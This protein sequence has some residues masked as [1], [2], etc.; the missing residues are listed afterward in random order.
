MFDFSTLAEDGEERARHFI[1]GERDQF[2]DR[3]VLQQVFDKL[4]EPKS[5]SIIPG[6]DHFLFG[7]EQ[8]LADAVREAVA[9]HV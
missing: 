9:D 6:A 3:D 8:A 4:P 1:V 2:C 5:M 7:R